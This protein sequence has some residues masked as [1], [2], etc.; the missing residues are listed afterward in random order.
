MAAGLTLA[1][2]EMVPTP[3]FRILARRKDSL[4]TKT[5]KLLS[6]FGCWILELPWG[7]ELGVWCFELV[8]WISPPRRAPNVPS[9]FGCWI[10]ELP[11]DLELGVWDFELVSWISPPRR[12][13]NVPSSFGCW[14]LELPWDLELG[15]WDFELVSWR[16]RTANASRKVLVLFQSPELS[17][18]PAIAFG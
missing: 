4:P 12:A 16:A 14:I 1:V 13:P 6:S 15:V 8:S 17:F 7:W 11:W 9:S 10:L 3:P 5:S 2:A 18:I